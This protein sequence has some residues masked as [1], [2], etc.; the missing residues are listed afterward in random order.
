MARLFA[1]RPVVSGTR[2]IWTCAFHRLDLVNWL[3]LTWAAGGLPPP[4]V[5]PES[6]SGFSP[7]TDRGHEVGFQV[8]MLVCFIPSLIMLDS[9]C[10][11]LP[12]QAK[13]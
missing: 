5:F 4:D 3:T 9:G 10:A 13:P 6:R 12:F 11:P 8:H 2:L 1:A 7:L